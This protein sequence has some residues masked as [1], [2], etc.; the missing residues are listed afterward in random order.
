[1][2]KHASAR[3]TPFGPPPLVLGEDEDAYNELLARVSAA[4]QP[5][6]MIEEILVRDIADLDWDICRLRR[7]K[8][9]LITATVSKGL[10][11]AFQPLVDEIGSHQSDEERLDT[12]ETVIANWGRRKRHAVAKVERLL[13][14]NNI[15]I[16]E[17]IAYLI[18]QMI[19]LIERI[20]HL[21]ALSEARRNATVREIDRHRAAVGQTVPRPQIEEGEYRVVE[22]KAA[23][24]K[25]A[26]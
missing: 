18:P 10:E 4:V 9:N 6:D 2:S 17:T 7:V 8:A 19:D 11:P 16:D 25:N 1:M 15:E 26:A 14:S 24:G 23:G 12:L 20:D 3:L 21:V 13:R 22:T 5:A